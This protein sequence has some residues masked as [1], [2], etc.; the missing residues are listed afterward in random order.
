M[1]EF[2]DSPQEHVVPAPAC[3]QPECEQLLPYEPKPTAPAGWAFSCDP[4]LA[5]HVS[6]FVALCLAAV[7]ERDL[8][9]VVA[10]ACVTALLCV[11]RQAWLMR[12]VDWGLLAVLLIVML[13]RDHSVLFEEILL[14]LFRV[15]PTA[16][17]DGP[18][19]NATTPAPTTPP[20]VVA[21]AGPN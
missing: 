8:F 16:P 13:Y 14:I 20:D 17:R 9:L 10:V 5:L 6:V 12:V 4:G 19:Q 18:A 21:A 11:V 7:T 3:K 2:A 1:Q 15:Y